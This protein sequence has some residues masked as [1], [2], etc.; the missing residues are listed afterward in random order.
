MST[1]DTSP[2]RV[3]IS[4]TR[5]VI[6]IGTGTSWLSA[7]PTFTPS[8]LAG[9]T[10]GSVTVLSDTVATAPVTYGGN[11]GVVT[12]SDNTTSAQARQGVQSYPPRLW[13]T[14]RRGDGPAA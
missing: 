13:V 5:E 12:W 4:Q 3:A 11:R 8:G 2:S 14:R 1:L 9:V 7:A 10:C 6:F